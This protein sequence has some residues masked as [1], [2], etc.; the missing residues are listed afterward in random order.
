M[1]SRLAITAGFCWFA[2]LADWSRSVGLW[3]AAVLPAP[4]QQSL[5][6]QES[7]TGINYTHLQ[8][9]I[10]KLGVGFGT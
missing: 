9:T 8:S 7:N 6:V 3:K 2:S 5:V 10:F 4:A 1:H